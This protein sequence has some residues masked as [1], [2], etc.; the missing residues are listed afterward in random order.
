MYDPPHLVMK[1]S[2]L[3][4]VTAWVDDINPKCKETV[5]SWKRRGLV[6][7]ARF[8]ASPLL[9]KGQPLILESSAT[10]RRTN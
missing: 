4:H 6:L 5:G 8:A 1:N 7:P 3:I 10:T 2:R 9:A